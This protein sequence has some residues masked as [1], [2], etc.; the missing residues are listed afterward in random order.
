MST[1]VRHGFVA[2]ATGV[3]LHR[4]VEAKVGISDYTEENKRCCGTHVAAM[5]EAIV[6]PNRPSGLT[7]RLLGRS[8]GGKIT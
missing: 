7:Q 6:K 2:I 8:G 4:A 5:N 3:P 1:F